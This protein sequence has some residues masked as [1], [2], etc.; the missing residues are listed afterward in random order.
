MSLLES[1]LKNRDT[2]QGCAPETGKEQKEDRVA[3]IPEHLGTRSAAQGLVVQQF[4]QHLFW[5]LAKKGCCVPGTLSPTVFL[6][7]IAQKV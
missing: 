6:F 7:R 4:T 2:K 1:S 5:L 3:L